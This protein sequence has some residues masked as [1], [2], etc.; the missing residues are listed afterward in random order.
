MLMS[1]LSAAAAFAPSTVWTPVMFL[2]PFLSPLVR[3]LAWLFPDAGMLKMKKSAEIVVDIVSANVEQRRQ[4]LQAEVH[5]LELV[6][7][8]KA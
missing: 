4:A 6:V 1:C 5:H 3:C 8:S 2:F 7:L